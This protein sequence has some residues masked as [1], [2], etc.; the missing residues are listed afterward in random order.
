[1]MPRMNKE[2]TKLVEVYKLSEL[3]EAN[4]LASLNDEA[5]RVL[6][7]T[8]DDMPYVL[9]VPGNMPSSRH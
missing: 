1:M 6:K 3:I 2:A 8:R 7:S 4:V 9:H 5:L